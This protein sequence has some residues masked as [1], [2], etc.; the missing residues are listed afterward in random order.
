MAGCQA[1]FGLGQG[2]MSAP[3]GPWGENVY[4]FL[5]GKEKS[6]WRGA[7]NWRR[8]ERIAGGRRPGQGRQ[9][10]EGEQRRARRGADFIRSPEPRASEAQAGADI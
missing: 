2:G 9:W 8:K 1:K 3:H 6:P 4:F 5:K 7:V 10:K